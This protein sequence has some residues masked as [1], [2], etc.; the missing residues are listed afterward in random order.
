MLYSHPDAI[1]LQRTDAAD[2]D[3]RALVQQLDAGLAELNGDTQDFYGQYNGL[4]AIRYVLLARR[5]G[6]AVGCGAIKE[7]APGAM[8]VKRMFVQPGARRQGI[9]ARVL[10]GLEGWAHELGYESTVLETGT[11]NPEAVAVYRHAGYE[12]IPNYGPYAG[13][14]S[15]IC[16]RKQLA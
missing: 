5:D 14:E 10:A 7:W 16:F 9:A 13:V 4:D 11:N 2:P 1:V 8:E 12:V 6:A 3:F 15:S